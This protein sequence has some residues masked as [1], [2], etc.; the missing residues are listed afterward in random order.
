[1]GLS[2]D[3]RNLNQI[4]VSKLADLEDMSRAELNELLRAELI[5]R[6]GEEPYT[7]KINKRGEFVTKIKYNDEELSCLIVEETYSGEKTFMNTLEKADYIA[8]TSRARRDINFDD[9]NA[10]TDSLLLKRRLLAKFIAISR[11]FNDDKSFALM[12]DMP[13]RR[14][15]ETYTNEEI[16]PRIH[17]AI[18]EARSEI[19]IVCPWMNYRLVKNNFLEEFRT[20]I[21]RGVTILLVDVFIAI[22]YST[23]T[24]FAR[25]RGLSTSQPRVIAA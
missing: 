22:I 18:R 12:N 7:C 15:N 2:K 25:L 1:M 3:V 23:V 8:N 10:I 19:A 17:K 24:D 21:A 20:A 14:A 6:C 13:A 4:Y 11:S 5:R 16:A 9:L